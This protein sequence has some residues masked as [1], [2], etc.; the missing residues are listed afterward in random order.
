MLNFLANKYVRDYVYSSQTNRTAVEVSRNSP[1]LKL[2]R[3]SSIC[4]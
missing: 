1:L 3:C 4:I 2:E